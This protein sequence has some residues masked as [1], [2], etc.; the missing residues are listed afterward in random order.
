MKRILV[1]TD[2]SERSDRAVQRGLRIAD[3]LGAACHALTVVDENLPADLAAEWQERSEARLI[4]QIDALAPAASGAVATALLGDPV[5]TIP[6]HA[7]EI[8]ADLL[9]VGLHRPRSFLDALRETTMERLVRLSAMPVLLVRNPVDD[10]Y[11]KVLALVSFSPACAAALRAAAELAPGVR[12]DAIHA[13]YV[14]FG[15]LTGEGPGS[16]MARAVIAEAEAAATA[17]RAQW[18]IAA[19]DVNLSLVPESVTQLMQ[20]KLAGTDYDMLAIGAHTRSGPFSAGLGS[21][22]SQLIRRPPTDL[23]VA[24][25]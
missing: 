24:L 7:A 22:A 13:V 16:A 11:D 14:P 23:L 25:P 4:R 8:G 5:A 1:A 20:R 12:P 18:G 2:L 10:D 19:E 21:F 9:V 17:W 6:A 3:R 15:G